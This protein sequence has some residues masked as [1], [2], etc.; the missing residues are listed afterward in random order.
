MLDPQDRR[1]LLDALRPPPGYRL[2]HAVGTT[3][4]LDLLALLTAPLAFTAFEWE[5]EHGRPAAD[6]YA[7]LA[8]LRQNASAITLFCQLGQ[9]GIPPA[10]QRLLAELE[11]SVIQVQ[12]PRHKEGGV[13]H[14]KVWVLRY[15]G[16]DEDDP[17]RYRLLCLSR[18]LTFDRS[19]DLALVLDGELTDRK[20]AIAVNH[21][22][23]D[24]LAALPDMS[25]DPIAPARLT[26]LDQLQQ[27]IRRVR[28]TAPE[29][30]D[31]AGFWPLGL[32]RSEPWP[33]DTRI[34]RLLVISP[35]LS[36]SR[37]DDLAQAGRGDVLISRAEELERLGPE[38]LAAFDG[39]FV[40]DQAADSSDADSEDHHASELRGLHAKAYLAD[41]GWR[42]TAW[43]GS[44]NATD[45]GFSLNVEFLVEL[46]GPKRALGI[47]AALAEGSPSQPS[48]RDLLVEWTPAAEPELDPV[49]KA[50]E[51]TC[52]RVRGE[53]AEGDLTLT[54]GEETGGLRTC[55]LHAPDLP[56]P[57]DVTV[58]CWLATQGPGTATALA[59]GSDPAARFRAAPPDITPF[60]GFE[61]EAADGDVR[62]HTRFTVK[63]QLVGD[64]P[65]RRE[66]VLESIL[67]D[68]AGLIRLLLLLLSAGDE[69][70]EALTSWAAAGP[71]ANGPNA[72]HPGAAV[73]LP[74]LEPLLLRAARDPAALRPLERMI[75]DLR[76]TA[77]G[78]ELLSAEVL[79]VWDAVWSAVGETTGGTHAR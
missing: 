58:S 55:A 50:L 40:L 7:L 17:V 38:E 79:G 59:P 26:K 73:D 18:N 54:V 45:A 72:D 70:A 5:D 12:A 36:G 13:F 41:Q 34:D 62:Q 43:V 2:D 27:E 4:S 52:D 1:L 37:L 65:G 64:P 39:T 66:A 35:F 3:F 60:V 23:G 56:L 57:A 11:E 25:R 63:V 69:S 33:F 51:A 42:A 21:P 9:I 44:T 29:E 46:E 22:V 16:D 24:F 30:L 61:V 48:F 10:H 14:P 78:R 8:A 77:E 75:T 49:A 53:L 71:A 76:S 74:L 31:I 20:N 32:D 15:A 19:W 6:P 68:R 28:F 67:R 47:A